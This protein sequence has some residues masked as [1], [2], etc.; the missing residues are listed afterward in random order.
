[1]PRL[2]MAQHLEKDVERI[3]ASELT[4][5]FEILNYTDR[6]NVVAAAIS[7]TYHFLTNEIDHLKEEIA[8]LKEKQE[9][10]QKWKKK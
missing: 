1:M 10:E 4:P 6:I 3:L 5:T 2:S 9:P 7:D 8:K